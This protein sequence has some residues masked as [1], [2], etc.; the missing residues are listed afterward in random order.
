[1]TTA[2]G[3]LPPGFSTTR[4]GT[5]VASMPVAVL[6][7]VGAA[8]LVVAAVL[9]HRRARRRGVRA[10]SP[11][12]LWP[13]AVLALVL[14]VAIGV[15][16]WV[17][18]LPDVTAVRTWLAGQGIGT[19]PLTTAATRDGSATSGAV[20]RVAVDAPAGL[21]VQNDPMWV[22]TPPGYDPARARYPVLYLMHGSPGT[23]A[24]WFAG[25]DAAATLDALIDA[26]SIPPLVVVA[27]DLDGTDNTDTE[28]LDSTN[29]GPQVETYLL[30]VVV[31]YVDAHYAT[32]ADRTGRA[33]GGMSSGG[34]CA[35]DLGLRHQDLFSAIAAI[36]PYTEPGDGGRAMLATQADF[37]R[38][39]AARYLPGLTFQEPM[40]VF[41]DIPGAARDTISG[42]E[43]ADLVRRLQDAGQDVHV[44]T[45]PGQ[46]H[47]W[48]TARLALPYALVDLAPDLAG[49]P[50]STRSAT[51][52]EKPSPAPS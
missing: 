46:G 36:E 43:S 31:P 40:H 25:G 27:P 34:F 26:G 7:V 24:D 17:G 49:S 6:V 44:R 41:V 29:G 12:L 5:W 22:Y 3:T 38:H 4:G 45:E 37:D 18:Y 23:P 39:D 2:T 21:G 28:C 32:V 15:N 30:D 47:T 51:D 48:T 19:S 9:A 33:V 20:Q 8:G 13:G 42:R 16:A 1:M 52:V 10:R 35:V 14:G 50:A 11:W